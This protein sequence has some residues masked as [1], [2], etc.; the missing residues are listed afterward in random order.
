MD[1]NLIASNRET[2]GK[3]GARKTRGAGK[4]PAVMYGPGFEPRSLSLD[5]VAFSTIFRKTQNPNT[6][7]HLD[8]EGENVTALVREVQRHPLS[9]EI[10]HVD[11]LHVDESREVV[12][13]VRVEAVGRPA[14][15]ALGGRVRIIRRT[16]DVRCTFD[17][18]P[19]SLQIDVSPMD[20]GD[21][22]RASDVVLPEGVALI[23]ES[24]INIV[25]VYGKRGGAKS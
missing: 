18:I 15:A 5:P 19:E 24:D 8:I 6:V 4:L 12:V 9:R 25:S 16:L 17:K 3:G 13:P 21:M 11:L 22:R 23:V 20:I 7:L 10:L 14:G 1:T 2:A